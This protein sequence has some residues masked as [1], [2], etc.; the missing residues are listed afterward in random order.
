[1]HIL[2]S[3]HPACRGKMAEEVATMADFHCCIAGCGPAGAM[4]GLLLVR[5]GLRVL[6]LEKH[7]DFLRDFRGDTVHPSTLD[8]LRQLGLAEQFL[9]IPH[10]EVSQI[11]AR[12]PD[13]SLVELDLRRLGLRYP[14]VAFVPQW[15]FLNWLT[16]EAGRYPGFTLRMS[17]EATGLIFAGGR[18]AGV[19]YRDAAGDHE[20]RAL[21][22]AGAD[23]RDSITRADATLPRRETSAPMDVWW[24]R[25][26]RKPSEPASVALRLGNGQIMALLDRGDYW[27]CAYVIPKGQDEV[28]RQQGIGSLRRAVTALAPELGD[29]AAEL[30][31]WDQVKLLTVRSDRLL[32]WY[33]PGYLAIGDAA[34]AMSPIGGVGINMAIQDAVA[35][36]NALWRPLRAGSV[37]ERD[38]AAAQRRRQFSI[39]LV[40]SFQAAIQQQVFKPALAAPQPISLPP[41]VRAAIRI[42][43]VRDLPARLLA[44]G[45]STPS[46]RSP[47]LPPADRPCISTH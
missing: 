6:V 46:V 36:A 19:R 7:G 8:V 45:L 29:R 47:A 13:G 41:V 24:F 21:L 34:H 42:P 40:Q 32:R 30:Q 39:H 23:G 27:Q 12:F 15:D 10:S 38:L 18:V 26:P 4:L 5:A 43:W 3:A 11:G 35:A 37:S 28:L 16:S 44:Y 33:R 25:L 1:M 31:E 22:I 17:A 2:G 14:F 9:Q 20:A